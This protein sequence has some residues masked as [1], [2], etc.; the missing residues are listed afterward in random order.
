M[1]TRKW[2]AS[3]GG[4]AE[5]WGDEPLGDDEE[6]LC[7]EEEFAQEVREL[8]AEDAPGVDRPHHG[9]PA[10]ASGLI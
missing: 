3:H 2:T 5:S 4:G 6:P 7:G 9:P 10:R 8:V 1:T